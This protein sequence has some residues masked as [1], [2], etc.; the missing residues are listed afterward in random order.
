[1]PETRGRLICSVENAI[2]VCWTSFLKWGST[3]DAA[4]ISALDTGAAE[5]V[6]AVA[7]AGEPRGF[8]RRAQQE[9]TNEPPAENGSSTNNRKSLSNV[10][11]KIRL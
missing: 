5:F 9:D 7:K 6:D 4:C 11:V 10:H 2:W 1:M 3:A 8:R